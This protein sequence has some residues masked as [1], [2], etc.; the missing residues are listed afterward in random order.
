MCAASQHSGTDPTTDSRE[1]GRLLNAESEQRGPDNRKCCESS[2]FVIVSVAKQAGNST[3]RMHKAH[4]VAITSLHNLLHGTRP[5]YMYPMRFFVL[6]SKP[7]LMGVAS[8]AYIGLVCWAF[9]EGKSLWWFQQSQSISPGEVQLF[10]DP[11]SK[12][13]FTCGL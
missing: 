4:Q 7:V 5:K 2:H 12:T 13:F 8:Y 9:Q 11:K 3:R 6:S 1:G 10:C